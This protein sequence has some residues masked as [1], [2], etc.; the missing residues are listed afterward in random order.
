M[1]PFQKKNSNRVRDDLAFGL[2]MHAEVLVPVAHVY[3]LHSGK[4]P[5]VITAIHTHTKEKTKKH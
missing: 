2:P 3:T 4:P 5:H 1:A